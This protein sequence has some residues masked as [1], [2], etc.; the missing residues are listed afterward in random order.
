MGGIAITCIGL[1][2][3]GAIILIAVGIALYNKL[4]QLRNR[5]ENAWAD[6]DV[7]LRRR[8]D[9]IPNLVETVKGYAGHEKTTLENVTKARQQAISVTGDIA[10]MAQ[11]EN[12]LTQTLRQLFAVAEAYPDLKANQ[13][14]LDLQA[15]LSKI[16][17]VLS[18]A[19]RYYNAVVRDLNTAI[20]TVPTNFVASIFSFKKREYFELEDAAAREAPKVDFGSGEKK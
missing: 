20:E 3:V 4:V 15:Q 6:I 11:A 5:S 12:F 1:I 19:R 14:F 18:E 16:E 2:L 17:E 8:Y 10:K 9:L 7:Q 13:S